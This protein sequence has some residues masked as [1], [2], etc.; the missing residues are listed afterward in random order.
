[1]LWGRGQLEEP[2]VVVVVGKALVTAEP[3]ASK[4]K[5]MRDSILLNTQQQNN[6]GKKSRAE[7][8]LGHLQGFSHDEQRQHASSYASLLSDNAIRQWPVWHTPPEG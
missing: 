4:D 1:M 5:V 2:V 3:R 6:H 8:D 7:Q